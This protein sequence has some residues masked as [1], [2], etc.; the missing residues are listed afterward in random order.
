MSQGPSPD[1]IYIHSMEVHMDDEKTQVVLADTKQ[2]IAPAVSEVFE[3]FG[4]GAGLLRS[5]RDVYIKVNGVGPEPYVYT[6]P[7]VLRETIMYF[8]RCGART[9]Y[10]M[11]N[12]MVSRSTSES[13]YT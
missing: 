1:Y 8:R 6:D 12:M 13:V 11:E 4:G 3:H 7:E 2:G 10:V 9:V 5:S